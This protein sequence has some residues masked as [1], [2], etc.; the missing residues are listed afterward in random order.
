M[1]WK[2]R[3]QF[4]TL[5]P[6]P[7][8]VGTWWLRDRWAMG[9]HLLPILPDSTPHPHSPAGTSLTRVWPHQ[10]TYY[11]NSCPL[12]SLLSVHLCTIEQS[13]LGRTDPGIQVSSSLCRSWKDHDLSGNIRC[14][15]FAVCSP[16]GERSL[17]RWAQHLP[18]DCSPHRKSIG[19]TL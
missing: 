5:G 14:H 19:P 7:Y 12:S 10:P 13:V 3:F 18:M 15:V 6:L 4:K 11:I 2:A 17:T 16:R 8:P 9:H 1:T